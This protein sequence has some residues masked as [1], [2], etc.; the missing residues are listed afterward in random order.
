MDLSGKFEILEEVAESSKAAIIICDLAGRIRV[1]NPAAVKLF[2]MNPPSYCSDLY[3]IQR[4]GE[5]QPM[6][7]RELPL[8]RALSGQVIEEFLEIR[9][10]NGAVRRVIASAHPLKG[11]G[12][13]VICKLLPFVAP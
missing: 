7:P 2:E 11:L 12:A 3:G 10:A 8:A 9:K 13:I 6:Q 4:R 5:E 1:F